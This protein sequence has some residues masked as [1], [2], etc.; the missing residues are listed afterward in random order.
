MN[1]SVASLVKSV[2][3]GVPARKIVKIVD[4]L[5]LGAR[6]LALWNSSFTT[7]EKVSWLLDS[8]D[9]TLD[10][11]SALVDSVWNDELSLFDNLL[12]YEQ[13][14]YLQP[15]LMRQDKMSM[16]ASVESRV[17]VLDN[18]MLDVANT[19]PYQYKVRHFTP[20]HVFKKVAERHISRKI[21]YKKKV[22]FG[23]PVDEWLRDHSGLGRY[24]DLLLDTARGINGVSR[25]RIEQLI[26]E[27]ASRRYNHGDVLWPLVNYAIWREQFF[28]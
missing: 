11:R 10:A 27:H 21:V 20:K 13:K 8:G 12:L 25:P 16:A 18:E 23:V 7:K 22:G 5:G 14:S 2:L 4:N 28:K 6:E 3:K 15:I 24:L 17:P 19:I 1:P 9:V 26:A